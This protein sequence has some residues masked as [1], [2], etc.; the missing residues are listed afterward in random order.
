MI[1]NLEIDFFSITK[2]TREREEIEEWSLTGNSLCRTVSYSLKFLIRSHN[3]IF[4]V[5]T[6]LLQCSFLFTLLWYLF[7]PFLFCPSIFPSK[8]RQGPNRIYRRRLPFCCSHGN[9]ALAGVGMTVMLLPH[10]P[11]PWTHTYTHWY[12][13]L[14]LHNT[15]TSSPHTPK[16]ERHTQNT[17]YL[18]GC[19]HARIH[20]TCL[21]CTHS[22]ANGNS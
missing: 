4:Y 19:T 13:T 8:S 18:Q 21:P 17:T 7:V 3:I 1:C 15:P 9:E 12:T 2:Y 22:G 5:L 11:P 20:H 10:T 14:P 16:A 6:L